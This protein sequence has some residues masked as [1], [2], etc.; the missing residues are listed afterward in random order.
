MVLRHYYRGG[1]V[2]RLTKDQFIFNG[3]EASRPFKE[4]KLLQHMQK[5]EL[6]VPQAIAAR[7]IKSSTLYRADILMSEIANTKTLMQSIT[8]IVLKS[9][10]WMRVGQVIAK[11]HQHGVHHVDLNANN[12]LIDQEENIYLIDF[13]RCQQRS[14]SQAWANAELKRLKRSLDKQMAINEVMNFQPMDFENLMRGYQAGFSSNSN[15]MS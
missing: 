12:I 1:L 8:E 14:F 4:M 6:P 5:M 2:A 10:V 11:F 7:C 15:T 13:D 3:F 9:D